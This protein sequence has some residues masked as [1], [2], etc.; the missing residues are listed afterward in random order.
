VRPDLFTFV[1]AA[2]E[3]VSPPGG[4]ARGG[5]AVTITGSG[6]AGAT[7]VLFGA[8][9]ATNFRVLSDQTI[10]A[11]APPQGAGIHNIFVVTSDGP[12]GF[13][14]NDQFVYT[15]PAITGI[16]PDTGPVAGGTIVTITGSG[17]AATQQVLFGDVPA[18]SFAVD[19]DS[20]ISAV[21]PAEHAGLHNVFVVT[22]DGR[23]ANTD[24]DHFT[25]G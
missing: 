14:T 5:T 10:M 7:Q 16:A 11:T 1:G 3:G 18:P 20:E 21:A 15:G 12:S 9:P 17:F 13:T 22:V 23:S 25:Y 6:F 2:V 24:D 8:V 19:S 4:P